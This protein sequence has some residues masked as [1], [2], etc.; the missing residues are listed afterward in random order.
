MEFVMQSLPAYLV[1][2][3]CRLEFTPAGTNPIDGRLAEVA[4]GEIL[5]AKPVGFS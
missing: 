2:I 1:Y 3:F 4:R 5:S